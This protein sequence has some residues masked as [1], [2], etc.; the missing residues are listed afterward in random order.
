MAKQ[1]ILPKKT[2]EKALQKSKVLEKEED[3]YTIQK[4]K[5]EDL[6]FIEQAKK[7]P[8]L[9]STLPIRRK[10]KAKKK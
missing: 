7:L 3:L 6:T 9:F 5:E 4:L 10:S 2:I 8:T 1:K